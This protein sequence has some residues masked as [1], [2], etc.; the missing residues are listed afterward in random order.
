MAS[1]KV[2][3]YCFTFSFTL[4]VPTHLLP[5]HAD[6]TTAGRCTCETRGEA[7]ERP[8]LFSCNFS[9]MSSSEDEGENVTALE[10]RR[11]RKRKRER[12]RRSQL[13]GKVF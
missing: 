4:L 2:L 9:M 7:F 1:R 10:Q 11:T 12:K 8:F 13:H 3:P 6:K 5:T